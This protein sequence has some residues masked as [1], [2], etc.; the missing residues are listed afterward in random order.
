MNLASAENSPQN[1]AENVIAFRQEHAYFAAATPVD[2][3][4]L[5][6]QALLMTD[7]SK[8]EQLLVKA[9][10]LWPQAPDVH[11]A[12]Y[13][14]YFVVAQYNQAEAAVWQALR[15]AAGKAGFN[16]NYRRLTCHSANWQ[17]LDCPARLYLFSLKALG[18]CRLRRGRVL[19]AYAVLKKLLEL[20]P[21]D[22]IGGAAFLAIAQSF[23]DEA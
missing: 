8:K 5:L 7:M 10:K 11:I 22:G 16:R 12:L 2:L 4:L 14:F 21:S 23:F 20:D 18:V 19:A 13:K 15:I 1:S 17:Q 6:D 3:Q 9:R